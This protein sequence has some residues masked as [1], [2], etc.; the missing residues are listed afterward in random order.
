MA[1]KLADD[2]LL[3]DF[4]VERAAVQRLVELGGVFTNPSDVVHRRLFCAMFSLRGNLSR[5]IE[6][7]RTRLAN[8]L[9]APFFRLLVA[10]IPFFRLPHRGWSAGRR[11][12]RFAKRP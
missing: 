2:K 1:S 9:P 8:A 10:P 6:V 11:F 4:V 12:G 3:L 7:Q 5:S